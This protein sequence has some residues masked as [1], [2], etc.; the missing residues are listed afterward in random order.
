VENPV[1]PVF[2]VS[3]PA[4]SFRFENIRWQ[5]ARPLN[6]YYLEYL[7]AEDCI[8][9]QKQNGPESPLFVDFKKNIEE[10]RRQKLS[11][12][13]DLLAKAFGGVKDKKIMDLTLGLAADSLKLV[14]F[15]AH[16]TAVE[17]QPLVYGLVYDALMREKN[18]NLNIRFGN[19]IDITSDDFDSFEAFYL[20][21]MFDLEKRT[22]LPKK[23]MQ[24]L[25]DIIGVNSDAEFLPLVQRLISK[26]KRV[27]IKRHPN[28]PAFGGLTP[29]R[30]YAG[31]KVRFE[32]F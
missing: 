8:V 17:R 18:I 32:V 11:A 10:W 31:K 22:A 24:F 12:K 27:V 16:V 2:C 28:A 21:P 9:L 19:A 13:S 25:H 7:I 23:K 20:D 26:K 30:I 1:I 14:F 3:P 5:S 6:E 29:K 4:A 15:G